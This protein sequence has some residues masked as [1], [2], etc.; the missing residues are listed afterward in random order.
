MNQ[1]SVYIP[2][3]NKK[4][5]IPKDLSAC[6]TRQYIEM[7]ALILQYQCNGIS[8]PEFRI[9]GLYKLLNMRSG[10]NG[11]GDTEKFANIYRTSLLLES[12]FDKGEDGKHTIKLDFIN[13]P[14]P[15]FRGMF[16][17]FYGPADEFNNVTFGEYVDGLG[18]F[19]DFNQTGELQY[20][21]NLLAVFYRPKKSFI[22]ISR[23]RNKFDGDLREAY[24]PANVEGRARAFRHQAIGVVFGF[25]L[26]F[27][28]FQKYMTSC[29]LYI[30]GR[31]ID[32]SLLFEDNT[33]QKDSGLPGTG[34]KG[35]IYSFAESGVFGPLDQV[36]RTPLWEALLRM[37]DIYKRGK[38][39][40]A[41][42]P[43]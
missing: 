20:L 27:A 3:T 33:P 29:T 11:I 1:H 10:G 2:A 25:Y 17:S 9:H 43:K 8:F 24:V 37:Y 14:V 41:N 19:I 31:E 13:N 32:M 12:F 35:V 34:M 23:L 16:R 15:S 26:L 39:Y 6:D 4:Y 28:S 30:E 7:A 18:H 40:E 22:G 42:Q 36:R 21:Y 38:D 5:Y